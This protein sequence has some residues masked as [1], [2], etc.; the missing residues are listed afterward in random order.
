M[1]RACANNSNDVSHLSISHLKK[2]K[3]FLLCGVVV[4]IDYSVTS[5]SEIKRKRELESLTIVIVSIQ[6]ITNFLR[7]TFIVRRMINHFDYI[8]ILVIKMR[9]FV[10]KY[11]LKCIFYVFF[12]SV[13]R[14]TGATLK[15]LLKLNHESRKV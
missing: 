12:R 5:I 8:Y 6:C 14:I 10:Q 3:S 1:S 13:H 11:S 2:S 9:N 15:T 4:E 7:L